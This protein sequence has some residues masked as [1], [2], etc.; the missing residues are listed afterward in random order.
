MKRVR[1]GLQRVHRGLGRHD[2]A[3][4][5][6][7]AALPNHGTSRLFLGAGRSLLRWTAVVS[8]VW[9]L[10]VGGSWAQ[11]DAPAANGEAGVSPALMWVIVILVGLVIVG[12]VVSRVKAVKSQ[13]ELEEIMEE[14]KDES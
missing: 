9:L 2:Q 7:V 14:I 13:K 12:I 6:A 4:S 8:L 10:F 3:G 11:A 5:A 1:W